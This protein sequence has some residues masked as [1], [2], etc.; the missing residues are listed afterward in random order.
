MES[1]YRKIYVDWWNIKRSTIYTIIGVIL[2]A[3]LLIWGGWWLWKNEAIFKNPELQQGPQDAARLIYFEGE[4]RVIRAATRETILVTKEIFVAAG[5]TIQT[6]ADGR[7]KIQMI[8]GSVLSIRPNSTIVIRSSASIFGGTNVRVGL[9][10]GQINVR[11]Q[12]QPESAEN[13]V[14]MRESENYLQPQTDASFNINEKTNG[15]EIRISR[16]GVETKIGDQKTVIKENEFASV[17]EG[18]IA[19]REK[20]LNQPQLVSPAVNEQIL[21]SPGGIAD[22]TFRWEKSAGVLPSSYH[23]QVAK[24]P[25]FV[26]DSMIL[27]R[28][29]LTGENFT[30]GNIS[31]GIYY[32]RVRANTDSGQVSDWSENG[33]FTIIRREAGREIPASDWKVDNLGGGVYIISGKTKPGAIIRISGRE[34]FATGDGSF[35]MQ[36]ASGSAQVSVEISD[37][38]GN[39]TRYALS[40]NSGRAIRQ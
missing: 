39:Q 25:F 36:I 38:K 32:W 16:G 19:N 12:D 6:Q 9:D 30:L 29:S 37:E 10:A 35:Q 13:V 14:E 33:K 17:N 34:T 11:T 31:P 26:S 40:L 28:D 18:K 1:K 15:G 8:D 20:L 21:S 5:D 24:S 3:A 22:I 2:S 7:A 4:V 27:V 23:L